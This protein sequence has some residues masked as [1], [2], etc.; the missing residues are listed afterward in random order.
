MHQKW[1]NNCNNPDENKPTPRGSI[2]QEVQHHW[3]KVRFSQEEVEQRR[4]GRGGPAHSA[5]GILLPESV[6]LRRQARDLRQDGGDP[7]CGEYRVYL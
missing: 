5:P 2:P 7:S 3:T 1:R 6:P 4:Q